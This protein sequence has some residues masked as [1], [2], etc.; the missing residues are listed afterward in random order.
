MLP[1]AVVAWL[2]ASVPVALVLGARL[3]AVTAGEPVL[4]GVY[5]GYAVYRLADGR[6]VG[7][8]LVDA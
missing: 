4:E 1:V 7:V 2:V 3:R 5:D 6:R 8:S